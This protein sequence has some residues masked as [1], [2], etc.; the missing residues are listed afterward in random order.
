M[1]CDKWCYFIFEAQLQRLA[2]EKQIIQFIP[3]LAKKKWKCNGGDN[4]AIKFHQKRVRDRAHLLLQYCGRCE[5]AGCV[6]L[7]CFQLG[8]EGNAAGFN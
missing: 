1:V 2:A 7:L 3:P 5:T 6:L 4:I 8:T